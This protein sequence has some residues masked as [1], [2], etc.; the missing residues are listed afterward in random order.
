MSIKHI[1]KCVCIPVICMVTLCTP[2]HAQNADFGI[3]T[4]LGITKKIDKHWSIGAEAGLRTRDNTKTADRW[5]FGLDA[6]YKINSYAKLAAGYDFLYDHRETKQTYHKD[7]SVNKVTPSYWWP[8][9]RFFVDVTGSYAIGRLGMSLRERYQ[10]TYRPKAKNKKYDTDDD[11]WEDVKSKSSN[12][13]RSRFA[14]EYNIKK[15]PLSP[16]ASI[17]L[18][19]GEGGLQKTR[20]TVGTN[21]KLNKHHNINIYYRYQSVNNNDDDEP[22][23]HVLGLGYTYKF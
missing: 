19:H 2:C 5:S 14:M 16:F 12:L 8:R 22:D 23:I 15:C 17:E 9:H 6:T 4:D 3:W 13:L 10:Y 21:Y 20:Y 18:F 11:E 7:G 1:L